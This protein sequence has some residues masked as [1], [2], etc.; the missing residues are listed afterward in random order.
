M[1]MFRCLPGCIGKEIKLLRIKQQMNEIRNCCLCNVYCFLQLGVHIPDCVLVSIWTERLKTSRTSR[2]E[3][4][5]S[6]KCNYIFKMIIFFIRCKAYK[7][8]NKILSLITYFILIISQLVTITLTL[9]ALY[10]T[11]FG[12]FK[13]YI[14]CN[15][16]TRK[17][18]TCSFSFRQIR[19]LIDYMVQMYVYLLVLV[20]VHNCF[21][22]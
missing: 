21:P 14:S 5:R 22:V 15:F 9:V 7:C 8:V 16:S 18:I 6:S 11:C 2:Q 12:S 1:L 17:Q 13:T 10:S 4:T 19:S 3:E 20:P